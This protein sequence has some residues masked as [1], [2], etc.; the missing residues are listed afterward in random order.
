MEPITTAALI[1]GGLAAGASGGQAIASGKM[2][3]KNRAWQEKMYERQ[4]QDNRENAEVAYQRQ[5]DYAQWAWQNFESPAA[6]RSSMMAAGINP[7][8]QGSSIQPMGTPQ[9]GVAPADSASVPSQGPYQNNPGSALVAGASS[10][11]EISMQ[12]IQA[13]N[14]QAQTE[15]TNATKL[16]TLA[17]TTSIENANSLFEFTRMAAESDALS[18]K[19]K[20]VVEGVNAEYAEIKAIQDVDEREARIAELWSRQEKNLA[21]AAKTD[22]DRLTVETLREGMK[23]LQDANIENVETDTGLKKAQTGTEGA[24]QDDLSAS[25]DLKRAQ[26]ETEDKLRD[27]RI[28]LTDRQAREVLQKIGLTEA[29]TLTEYE[30]LVRSM[31]DTQATSTIWGLVD[32]LA[33]RI[34]RKDGKAGYRN[35]DELRE[36]L[37]KALA[38]FEKTH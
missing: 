4:K 6:Q 24:K 17:E 5:K 16:K 13:E 15:L 27:G 22:A 31:T 32:R 38:E 33:A 8:A 11:R 2:N 10:L 34:G 18:K 28:K 12:A 21:D 23:K 19:F 3:R 37:V 7:F 20:S 9:A 30:D 25:A 1:A 35:A 36:K 14:I 29:Q 26:K